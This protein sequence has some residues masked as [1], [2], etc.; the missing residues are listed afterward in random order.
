MSDNGNEK[1]VTI[2][3]VV[4]AVDWNDDGDVTQVAIQTP[5]EDEYIVLEEGEGKELL[6]Y[7]NEEVEVQ[8]AIRKNNYGD[9]TIIV[10]RFDVVS[11]PFSD[12]SY[13]DESWDEEF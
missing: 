11:P 3:G 5:D 13:G 10:E 12:D 8:G 6:E 2:R 1:W 4:S 7:E 9:N